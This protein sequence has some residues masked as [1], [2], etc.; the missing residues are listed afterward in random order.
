MSDLRTGDFTLVKDDLIVAKVMASNTHGN[1]DYTAPNTSGARIETEP[2]KVIPAPYAGTSE[3]ASQIVTKWDALSG[4]DTGSSGIITITYD[5]KGRIKD[6][7]SWTDLIS[8]TLLTEYPST[9]G[10]GLTITPGTE[11]EYYVI[12][13]NKYGPSIDSDIGIIKASEAPPSTISFNVTEDGI[14][15]KIEFDPPT[16]YDDI[17]EYDIVIQSN[18]STHTGDYYSDLAHCNGQDQDIMNQ[19]F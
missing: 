7:S 18:T 16:V 17:L 1:T 15:I 2:S 8:G 3:S 6:A 13:N 14:Y 10:D 9:S 5:L 11:Y 12:A 19:E 4:L